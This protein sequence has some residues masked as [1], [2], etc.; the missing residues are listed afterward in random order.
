MCF[1][2]SLVKIFFLDNSSKTFLLQE[3]TTS[4]DVIKMVLQKLE[5]TSINIV[6]QYYSLFESLNGS[7]I[8]SPLVSD[9]KVLSIMSKWTEPTAKFVFMIRLFVPVISGFVTQDVVAAHMNIDKSAL[10]LETYFENTEITH[11]QL[12]YLQYIQ[13]CYNVIT[14]Q[15]PTSPELAIELGAYHFIFKFQPSYN[16]S[17]YSVGFL[18][19]RIVEFLPYSHLK[20]SNLSDWENR[21][22]QKVQEILRQHNDDNDDDTKP[23]NPQRKY[24]EKIMTHLPTCY[25][26]SF[27]RCSQVFLVIINYYSLLIIL[28]ITNFLDTIYNIT[29]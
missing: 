28:L 9:D 10:S 1:I 5:I 11:P 8:D 20:G 29:S 12:L 4:L 22:L 21:L 19:D 6:A 26:N 15:Y 25:G 27:F 24:I 16:Q 13:A 3:D 18:T 7:S 17:S 14:G 23:L 2:Y